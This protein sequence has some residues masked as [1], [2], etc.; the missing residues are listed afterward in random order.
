MPGGGGPL[1]GIP[2][3]GN[4]G[5]GIPGGGIPRPIM[6]GGI[7]GGIPRPVEGVQYRGEADDMQEEERVLHSVDKHAS[8]V[9]CCAAVE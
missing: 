1:G 4:P 3:S 7:P 9:V 5:G 8:G 2:C 6:G